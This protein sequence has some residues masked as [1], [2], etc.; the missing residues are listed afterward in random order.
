MR[1]ARF[2]FVFVIPILDP[3]LTKRE[4]EN[5]QREHSSQ[6]E[7]HDS[8]T[9]KDAAGDYLSEP[10][11]DDIYISYNPAGGG[12]FAIHREMEY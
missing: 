4:E 7:L 2:T 3:P 12:V 11:R 9:S 10:H 1:F 8:Y 5:Y 6:Q